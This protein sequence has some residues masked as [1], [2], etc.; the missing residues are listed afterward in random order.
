MPPR[1]TCDCGRCHKCRDREGKARAY[2]ARAYGIPTGLVSADRARRHLAALPFGPSAAAAAAGIGLHTTGAIAN[3]RR[4]R[5]TR[6]VEAAILAVGMRDGAQRDPVGAM[7]RL[8]A[9][10]VLGW[11]Q[12]E[13]ARRLGWTKARVQMLAAGRLRFI[14]PA[15]ERRVVD[16]YR[17]LWMTPG[18]SQAAAT[19]A[20]AKSWHAPLCWDDDAL[21][22]PDRGPEPGCCRAAQRALTTKVPD[23]VDLAELATLV[24]ARGAHVAAARWGMT[25]N[26]V[27]TRLRRGGW[28]NTATNGLPA[29]YV[30]PEHAEAS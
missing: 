13:L 9:L 25:A 15:S 18:P 7:R 20:R 10:A 5:I 21:D 26:A 17:T 4:T 11:P 8:R 2:R 16:L 28:R 23:L 24:N 6:R 27:S 19:I 3:G 12:A 30:P 22:D 29:R 14:L 1:R